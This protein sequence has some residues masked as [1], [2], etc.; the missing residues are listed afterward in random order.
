MAFNKKEKVFTYPVIDI[1]FDATYEVTGEDLKPT[2]E[3]KPV[4]DINALKAEKILSIKSAAGSLLKHTDWYVIRKAERAT[5]IP[6][7]IVAERLEVITKSTTFE[8]EINVLE[9][10]LD[11]RK[12]NFSFLPEIE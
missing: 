3:I 4:Y 7:S 8:E 5:D 10:Y 2:G 12:Y 6:E 9:T 1:D 11:V